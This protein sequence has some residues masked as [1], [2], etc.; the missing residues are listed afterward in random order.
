MK[1]LCKNGPYYWIKQPLTDFEQR[2]MAGQLTRA[3]RARERREYPDKHFLL[4]TEIYPMTPAE[5]DA[6]WSRASMP[7]PLTIFHGHPRLPVSQSRVTR[8]RSTPPQAAK[9]S[10]P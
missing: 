10:R 1:V 5:E 7:G 3:E 8:P 9:R 2:M 4:Q 6:R